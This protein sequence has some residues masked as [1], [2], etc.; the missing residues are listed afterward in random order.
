MGCDNVR[1]AVNRS[2]SNLT[3]LGKSLPVDVAQWDVTRIPMRNAMADVIISDLPFG[4]RLGSKIDNRVL[5]YKALIELARVTRL[6]SGRAVLLTHDR[7]SMNKV[8]MQLR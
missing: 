2:Q 4:K 7:N 3:N 5:Y 6:K 8:F 1:V